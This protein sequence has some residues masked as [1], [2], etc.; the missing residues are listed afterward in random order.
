[1]Y[2]R[3]ANPTR[4]MLQDAL[5]ALDGGN[6]AFAFSSGLGATTVIISLLKHGDHILSSDDLY[7]GTNRLLRFGL[8]RTNSRF[9]KISG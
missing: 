3:S 7:G 8:S 6:Q 4:N 2:S 5:A 1:M 9:S